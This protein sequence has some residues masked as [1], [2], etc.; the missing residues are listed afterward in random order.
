MAH[1]PVV[2]DHPR[3]LARPAVILVLAPGRRTLVAHV[4]LRQDQ[5][6]RRDDHP[7]GEPVGPA[8]GPRRGRV[9]GHPALDRDG[10]RQ[11]PPRRR[12]DAGLE[13]AQRRRVARAARARGGIRPG[14]EGG[15][16]AAEGQ[17]ERGDPPRAGSNA[18]TGTIAFPHGPQPSG[19]K[20]WDRRSRGSGDAIA[21]R[22]S[23]GRSAPRTAAVPPGLGA[24]SGAD[25][26]PREL[27][28]RA[29]A[30]PGGQGLL[31]EPLDRVDLR[32]VD[33]LPAPVEDHE[34]NRRASS[35]LDRAPRRRDSPGNSRPDS[36]AHR[37]LPRRIRLELGPPPASGAPRTP[38]T[39]YRPR[40]PAAGRT[41]RL[42][43]P[44]TRRRPRPGRR[45]GRPPPRARARP[46][47]GGARP[48]R[49]PPPRGPRRPRGGTG[50]R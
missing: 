40:T 20:G 46:P 28:G 47:A 23:A 42:S 35:I 18:R 25:Q 37:C 21:Y 38:P 29:W 49:G 3:P 43:D 32:R 39:G 31:D 1:R 13:L 7:G 6:I 30:P 14:R 33:G 36:P 11:D 16:A 48:P 12:S 5:A 19:R 17:A 8:A 2:Q 15:K 26:R 4:I 9:V 10:R 24:A 50:P 34:R 41:R 22:R 27:P 45:R 44:P